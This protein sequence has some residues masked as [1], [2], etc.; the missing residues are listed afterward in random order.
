MLSPYCINNI[1]RNQLKSTIEK[2]AHFSKKAIQSS[3]KKASRD[4]MNEQPEESEHLSID[5]FNK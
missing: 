5:F 4:Y 1:E 3:P 2:K